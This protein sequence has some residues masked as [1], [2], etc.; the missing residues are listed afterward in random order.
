MQA[1]M[2]HQAIAAPTG[3][4]RHDVP[5]LKRL[6]GKLAVDVLPAAFVSVLGGFIVTQY[7]FSHSAARP[8]TVQVVP[9]SA[10]ML[11]LVR[12]E[13]AAIIDYLKM[14]LAAEKSRQATGN[15]ADAH[16]A[17]E[18][19]AATAEPAAPVAQPR[20][21]GPA[22]VATA[23]AAKPVA[24]RTKATAATFAMPPHEPLVIAQADQTVATAPAG[25]AAAP[26]EPKSLLTRT[27]EIK[28]QMVGATLHVVSAIGSIPSWIA[29][30]GERSN[31]AD[32]T[33]SPMPRPFT[34]PS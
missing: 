30:I 32:A 4:T 8:A 22:P 14:E 26:H 7:Q 34:Q 16:A 11:Q 33:L 3:L 28:D 17:A 12:D 29:S 18:A 15:V 24:V 9:A 19:E 23:F 20:P 6:L 27:M 21:A 31:G 2:Q 5:W 13:H 10:E 25:A 1:T